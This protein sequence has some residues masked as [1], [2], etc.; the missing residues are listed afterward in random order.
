MRIAFLD[1]NNYDQ[2]QRKLISRLPISLLNLPE[3]WY[4]LLRVELASEELQRQQLKR[5]Q[6]PRILTR[7][8]QGKIP[9]K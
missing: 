9:S 3:Y 8:F 2:Q 1:W 5:H 4:Y 7:K 6:G